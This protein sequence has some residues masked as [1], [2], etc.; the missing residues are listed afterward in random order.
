MFFPFQGFLNWEE[1]TSEK[2]LKEGTGNL[3]DIY[4]GCL[5]YS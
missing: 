4:L 5:A 3:L 2:A 1:E